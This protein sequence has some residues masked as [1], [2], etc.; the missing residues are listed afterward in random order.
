M[1][2]LGLLAIDIDEFKVI[3][4]RSWASFSFIMLCFYSFD[5]RQRTNIPAECS[6]EWSQ[7][8]C[9]DQSTKA[10]TS[11]KNEVASDFRCNYCGFY[12]LLDA[13]L[14]FNAHLH[15][16]WPRQPG[17]SRRENSFV[18]GRNQYFHLHSQK[19]GDKSQSIIFFFG[20]SNSVVNPLIY[21]AFQLSPIRSRKK[22]KNN[23]FNRSSVFRSDQKFDHQLK[24]YNCFGWFQRRDASGSLNHKTILT[25]ITLASEPSR[26]ISRNQM[27]AAF[28]HEK[29]I[30]YQQMIPLSTSPLIVS[31][32]RSGG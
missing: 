7:M 2:Y 29:N 16:H 23:N 32:W 8:S 30:E 20:M 13:V 6:V 26:R 17:K 15:V 22:E 14:R 1:P 3:N 24:Q 19:L 11:C 31:V 27:H 12:H 28:P 21:G 5:S 9:L 10:N 18:S 25:S 4:Y